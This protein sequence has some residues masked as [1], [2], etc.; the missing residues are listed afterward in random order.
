[1]GRRVAGNTLMVCTALM[2]FKGC[3]STSCFADK[4]FKLPVDIKKS[5]LLFKLRVPWDLPEAANPG[6]PDQFA[7]G[8][9]VSLGLCRSPA[10]VIC[11]FYTFIPPLPP[12]IDQQ[13]LCHVGGQYLVS[14][15]Q[16]IYS[17]AQELGSKPFDIIK[18]NQDLN[19][20]YPLQA[21]STLIVP[22]PAAAIR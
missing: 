18:F 14:S 5:T 20:V 12:S 8:D 2:P 3:S 4:S 22:L 13:A 10:L 7:A 17:V 11:C 21:G 9:T 6:C 1:M 19:P 16:T 15:G